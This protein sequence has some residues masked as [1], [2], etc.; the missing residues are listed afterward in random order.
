[1]QNQNRLGSTTG[2]TLSLCHCRM[3]LLSSN[4][5]L[6]FIGRSTVSSVQNTIKDGKCPHLS[7]C[8][9]C[10]LSLQNMSWCPIIPKISMAYFQFKCC[11]VSNYTDWYKISAWP[12]D[13]WVPDSCCKFESQKCGTKGN[14]SEW[15][16]AVSN[17]LILV[18]TWVCTFGAFYF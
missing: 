4:I 7:Y 8:L 5:S 13:N 16:S 1:M 2:R 3:S 12:D 18:C 11:G 15:H 10:Y 6:S 17:C 14:P 9:V